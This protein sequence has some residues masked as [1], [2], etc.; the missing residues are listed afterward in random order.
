MLSIGENGT[1]KHLLKPK[2]DEMQFYS[3]LFKNIVGCVDRIQ[4]QTKQ[5]IEFAAPC[6]ILYLQE[7]ILSIQYTN[8]YSSILLIF[9]CYI[10]YVAVGL[11]YI[12]YHVIK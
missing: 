9:P 6:T 11:L 10:Q 12:I 3:A 4:N 1:F 7:E 2:S 8:T 5:Q